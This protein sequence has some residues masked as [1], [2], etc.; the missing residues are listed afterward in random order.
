MLCQQQQLAAADIHKACLFVIE[1][2]R[3]PF[4][5]DNRTLIPTKHKILEHFLCQEFICSMECYE[6]RISN[7]GITSLLIELFIIFT[8]RRITFVN[9]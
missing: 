4:C 3:N 8:I 9:V 6:E 7:K 1:I 2:Q 5:F